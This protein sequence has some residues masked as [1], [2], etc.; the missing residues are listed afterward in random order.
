V[1]LAAAAAFLTAVAL[2]AAY[3]PA[4]RASRL[5]PLVVLRME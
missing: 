2:G 3:R 1:S 5:E 4:R